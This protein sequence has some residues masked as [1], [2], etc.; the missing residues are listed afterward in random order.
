M[1]ITLT[2]ISVPV[3]TATW[4]HCRRQIKF[5]GR[6]RL[7]LSTLQQDFPPE[8]RLSDVIS[9]SAGLHDP[10]RKWP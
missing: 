9:S 4:R 10:L 3:K 8:W 5:N 7:C 1:M 6:A 2:L